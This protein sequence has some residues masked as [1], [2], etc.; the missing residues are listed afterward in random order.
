M[1]P[2]TE[3][4]DVH[5]IVVSEADERPLLPITTERLP[6]DRVRLYPLED[7]DETAETI[8]EYERITALVGLETTVTDPLEDFRTLYCE[9][10]TALQETLEHGH[11]V[12][13]NVAS[14][15][16]ATGYAPIM[17]ALTLAVSRPTERSRITVYG[18]DEDGEPWTLPTS[19]GEPM[20]E[21]RE[22]ILETIATTDPQSSTDV[23]RSLRDID[24]GSKVDDSFR[25]KITYHVELLDERGL[26]RRVDDGNRKRPELTVGGELYL[27]TR[28]TA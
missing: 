16:S 19:I 2:A 20:I 17:A 25:S 7:T 22:R 27:E 1:N 15:T 3:E 5:H 6:A 23:A 18:A 13:V 4:R 10:Y 11:T 26:V 9:T 28:D 24:P 8:A 12:W 14:V 21:I